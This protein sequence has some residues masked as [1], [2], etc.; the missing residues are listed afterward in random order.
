MAVFKNALEIFQLTDKSNCRECNKPTCLAFAG[1]VFQG[2]MTLDQCPRMD[3]GTLAKYGSA[4]N[5]DD[6]RQPD[7]ERRL[8]ALRSQVAQVDMGAAAHRLGT[9]MENGKL[10][11]KCMGKE[12]AVDQKGAIFTDLHV[13]GWLAMP[14]LQYVLDGGGVPVKDQWVPF[15]E[16]EGGKTWYRLFGQQCEKPLKTVADNYTDLFEDMIRLFSGRQVQNHYQSDISLVLQPLPR[17]P[18]LICYWR[19]EE[20]LESDLHLFFD[21]TAEEN[22]NIEALYTLAV[23]MTLMFEKIAQRHGLD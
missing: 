12:I 2:Q 15:R 23:G 19:P 20:G 16:L 11:F 14:I 4:P 10:S 6:D 1:A 8:A 13:H 17:V 3:A 21:A 9:E 7:M 18:M 22:L 5:A